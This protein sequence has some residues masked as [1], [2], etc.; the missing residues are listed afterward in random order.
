[1]QVC[2]GMSC[3]TTPT[4]S[5][6]KTLRLQAE[7]QQGGPVCKLKAEGALSIVCGLL[8]VPQGLLPGLGAAWLS[9]VDA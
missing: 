4:A 2:S 1:M 8:V 5:V 6:S 7:H 3:L 9:H